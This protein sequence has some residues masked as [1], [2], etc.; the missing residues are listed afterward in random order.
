M[1]YLDP[2]AVSGRKLKKRMKL[3]FLI[4]CFSTVAH[5]Q[6]Y[7]T[8]HSE[9]P[10]IYIDSARFAYLN[11]N[12]G[13]GECGATF[14]AF[15]TAV[16]NNWYN[17]PQ[18]YLLGTDSTAWTWDFDS[19]WAKYQGQFVPAL[20]GIT[21]DPTALKRCRFLITRI[22][23]ELDAHDFN[24]HTWYENEDLIRKM[25]DVGGMLL[26]WCYGSLPVAMRQHLAQNLYKAESYFMNNY[27]L[28]SA[29]TAYVTGHNIWN[30]YYA[31][32]L[33]LVLDSADGL[34]ALQHDSITQWYQ[35]TYDKAVN[36]ILPVAGHYRDDDGGWNW[37]AAYSM[38]SLVDEFQFFENM[39]IATGKDFYTDLPWIQN[40]INQYWYFIQ[41]NGWTINWGD[42]FSQVQGDRVIYRHAQIY[43]DPRSLWLA[44]FYAQPINLTWTWPI[45]QK[46]MYKDFTAAT[47]TKPDLAHDWFSDR[48]GLSVSRTDWSDTATMVWVYDAPTKKAGHEHRD[49]N[50]FCIYKNAPQI[51]NSGYY[52]SYGNPH[53]VNYYM[54][55]IAHNSICVYDSTENYTNWQ[56]NV[57]NDGGQ[58]ESPTL[59]NYNDIF[60]AEAQKG[61]W[62]LW[63]AGQNYCYSISDAEQS[64]DPEKL[65]RFRRR[66]LFYKPDQVIVLDHLHLKNTATHQRDAKFIL[67][68]QQQPTINGSIVST[69]VPYHIEIF[70]GQDILQANGNGNIAIR[71]LLPVNSNTTRIGGTGYEFYVDGINY[72]L[73]VTPDTVHTTPGAWRIEVQPTTVVDSLIF[74]HTIAIGDS[75]NPSVPG[76]IAQHN[77]FTIGVD[78]TNTLFFFNALGDTNALY[79]IMNNVIGNR[80]VDIIGADLIPSQLYDVLVDDYVVTSLYTDSVGIL[81]TS[82]L[83]SPGDHK[84]EIS[85]STTS[86]E[87]LNDHT[88]SILVFPNPTKNQLNIIA[89]N[90]SNSEI[91]IY[92]LM[93]EL[94]MKTKNT[95][96][97]DVSGLSTGIYILN[98]KQEH[99]IYNY[100]FMKE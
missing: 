35:V 30:V 19:Q 92:D 43:N 9:R 52:W 81:E 65:D 49:N 98:I 85:N 78:W 57:S 94:I 54:R 79:Q 84:V 74:L 88:R 90:M 45:F 87:S 41:P 36:E 31:N 22:N 97:I 37:Q 99:D 24:D 39:R 62:E 67:H 13:T 29:G 27:I 50:S 53:Y 7:P 96:T 16:F 71:T 58:N 1:T 18:L 56:A 59:M 40:S 28:T 26:D 86:V 8:V 89:D 20:Y 2:V 55:T 10:R 77:D 69:P 60:S 83:L 38:W 76:G 68:F 91:V 21:N 34:S 64:Y 93:G 4:L 72:P 11:S 95:S 47:V 17:D 48:T 5:A 70:D 63:G 82:I 100:R 6:T 46:L 12:M 44:Q 73:G 80:T 14:T 61:S 42:G 3:F 66:V 51:N 32:Q 23:S 25:A 75:T 15:N 33:A